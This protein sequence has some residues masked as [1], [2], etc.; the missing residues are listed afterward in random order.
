M[1]LIWIVAKIFKTVAPNIII[2]WFFIVVQYFGASFLGPCLLLFAIIYIYGRLPKLKHTILLFLPGLLCFL[3]AATNPLHNMF[4]SVFTFYKDSFGE[5]FYVCMTVNYIYLAASIILLSRGF[6]KM[7]GIERARAAI[8][9][10]AII[11]PLIINVFYVFKLFKLFWG[12]R[13]LFDYTPIATNLSLMLFAL[14][15]MKYRFFDIL[16]M[17][18]KQLFQSLSDGIIICDSK[19]RVCAFNHKAAHLF[20]EIGCGKRFMFEAENH[21]INERTYRLIKTRL[22]KYIIYRFKDISDINSLLKQAKLKNCELT[23]IKSRLEHTLSVKQALTALKAKNYIMQELHDVLGHSVVLAISACEVEKIN[24]ARNYKNTLY[25]IK[26]LL[27]E[28]QA[29]LKGALKTENSP[30]RRTSLIIALD[31]IIANTTSSRLKVAHTV[32]GKPFELDSKA[33]KAVFRLCQ[34]AITNSIK[35]S[36]SDEAYIVLR[37][38]EDKLEIIIMDNGK[39]CEVIVPGKGLLGMRE[40][41]KDIGGSIEFVSGLDCGFRIHAAVERSKNALPDNEA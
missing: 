39:G 24:E 10:M 20:K 19:N 1:L 22:K 25:G 28:S 41:I 23:D 17:A 38:Y 40:R 32:I 11:L 27:S 12:V 3:V 26:K 8:F 33:S 31:S 36:E 29:E 6:L 37:Y 7:F 30:E 2:R 35:H 18:R 13:P 9:T 4:Y 16:P 21:E 15:S 5:L 34:E 14:G